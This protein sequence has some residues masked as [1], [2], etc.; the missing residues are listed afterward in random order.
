MEDRH[1]WIQAPGLVD[2]MIMHD[3]NIQHNNHTSLSVSR[4]SASAIGSELEVFF[5][6]IAVSES[7]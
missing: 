1:H 4:S 6:T 3:N 5:H 7:H 2:I